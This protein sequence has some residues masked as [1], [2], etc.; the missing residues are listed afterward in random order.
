MAIHGLKTAPVPSTI[1]FAP[2]TLSRIK[3]HS[4]RGLRIDPIRKEVADS[5]RNGER[6][7]V[8]LGKDVKGL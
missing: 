8:F 1:A 6:R 7:R 3:N 5:V 4:L 2:C